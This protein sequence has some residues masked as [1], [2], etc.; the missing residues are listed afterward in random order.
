MTKLIPL[1]LFAAFATTQTYALTG[2]PVMPDYVQFEAPDA[3]NM[4]DYKSGDF[5][6]NLPLG[7]V[8]GPSGDFPLSMSYHAGINP[9]QEATWVGLGW[10]LN[11]GVIHRNVNGIADDIYEGMVLSYD[12]LKADHNGYGISIGGG[13]GPYGLDMN[14]SS[15]EGWG[16][17]ASFGI[18]TEE[19]NVG[20][21]IGS[22][23][24]VGYFV[25]TIGGIG[26]KASVGPSGVGV[27]ITERVSE[28]GNDFALSGSM[29]I[30]TTWEGNISVN[31]GVGLSYES[32]SKY[33]LELAGASMSSQSGQSLSVGGAGFS[34]GSASSGQGQTDYSSEE[35]GGGI[36][37]PLP[38]YFYVSAGYHWYK[39]KW[40]YNIANEE[41]INGYMYQG[42]AAI[43]DLTRNDGASAAAGGQTAH[44]LAKRVGDLIAPGNTLTAGNTIPWKLRKKGKALE[45]ID[46]GDDQPLYP[47][48]DDYEVEAVGLMGSFR[49]IAANRMRLY[50]VLKKTDSRDD[51]P[52]KYNFLLN[53]RDDDPLVQRDDN[54]IAGQ[55]T[56]Y[57]YGF[58]S[59]GFH[60][61]YPAAYDQA[62]LDDNKCTLQHLAA[63]NFLNE[64]NRLVFNKD[65]DLEGLDLPLFPENKPYPRFR[66]EGAA[67]SRMFF[68]FLGEQ[69]GGF[70][71]ENLPSAADLVHRGQFNTPYAKLPDM[72]MRVFGAK[73]IDPILE[74]NS[75][76]G[77][78]KGF[79][80][81]DV[82][83]TVY[84]FTQPVHS[85]IMMSYSTNQDKGMPPV[86]I[87][88]KF[89]R[90]G[91][92]DFD[93]R[94]AAEV[95]AGSA[96][97]GVPGAGTA[98]V[99]AMGVSYLNQVLGNF[100]GANG[101]Y[102][103]SYQLS[104][105]PYSTQW[106]LS[107]I[108]GPNFVNFE[109]FNNPQVSQQY[110]NLE[111]N[112]KFNYTEP[113]EIAW[114][115]P[116]V[117]P[118]MGVQDMT[119][120][121][122]EGT[123]P[124]RRGA[125]HAEM[126]VKE[127]V[128]LKS[129]ET[130]T[131]RADFILNDKNTEERPDSRGLQFDWVTRT[132][133]KHGLPIAVPAK[134]RFRVIDDG[135]ASGFPVSLGGTCNA[136]FTSR[137]K[138]NVMIELKE[139]ILD[140]PGFNEQQLSGMLGQQL[141]ITHLGVPPFETPYPQNPW[142]VSPVYNTTVQ[143]T[144]FDKKYMYDP[145]G[146]YQQGTSLGCPANTYVNPVMFGIAN[147]KP[148]LAWNLVVRQTPYY[149]LE[150]GSSKLHVPI[151]DASD[152]SSEGIE[153]GADP[154]GG[155]Y[156]GIVEKGIPTGS[157]DFPS[158]FYEHPYTRASNLIDCD[159]PSG[160]LHE[161]YEDF[162][163]EPALEMIV[164]LSEL[165]KAAT[166]PSKNPERYLK[167]IEIKQK[168]PDGTFAEKTL[169]KFEFNYD[170]SLSPR[171]P[172]S[173]SGSNYPDNT[174]D[175][176]G[177]LTLKTVREVAC[178]LEKPNC[179]DEGAYTNLPPWQFLYQG[180]N[181]N[182]GLLGPGIATKSNGE[183][184]SIF[185]SRVYQAQDRHDIWGMYCPTCDY[186]NRYPE[187]SADQGVA[188]NLETVLSP[189]FAGLNIDYERDSFVRSRLADWRL[190][191]WKTCEEANH[192]TGTYECSYFTSVDYTYAE[193]LDCSKASFDVLRHATFHPSSPSQ[194]NWVN[195]TFSGDYAT[196]TFR[197]LQDNVG[198]EVLMVKDL[199]G[200]IAF[201]ENGQGQTIP[202]PMTYTFDEATK[203]LNLYDPLISRYIDGDH[204]C[205]E[206]ED[207]HFIVKP[208]D[209]VMLAAGGLPSLTLARYDYLPDHN[210]EGYIQDIQKFVAPNG[211]TQFSFVF[212]PAKGTTFPFSTNPNSETSYLSKISF[213]P[214]SGNQQI[215]G[216][217]LRV[218]SLS[219]GED[220]IGAGVNVA[221]RFHYENG[222]ILTSPGSYPR[223]VGIDL[224]N[225]VWEK[226]WR[227]DEKI[228]HMD[229]SYFRNPLLS[230]T[231]I[232]EHAHA[233]AP[234]PHVLYSKVNVTVDNIPGRTE[235]EFISPTGLMNGLSPIYFE[236]T[237]NHIID[238]T[239]LIG[240][241]KSNTIYGSND[242]SKL[243][244][245]TEFEY[246]FSV[247][248]LDGR[249][250]LSGPAIE[251]LG[252]FV[253][254]WTVTKKKKAADCPGTTCAGYAELQDAEMTY[255]RPKAFLL[256]TLNLNGKTG[257]K[258]ST[259]NAEF[260]PLTGNP[261]TTISYVGPES[262]DPVPASPANVK[263]TSPAYLLSFT[264]P[265]SD[266][267][268]PFRY[269]LRK[270]MLSQVVR[271]DEYV[272][273][274]SS[275]EYATA[276]GSA[277]DFRDPHATKDAWYPEGGPYQVGNANSLLVGSTV[278]RWDDFQFGYSFHFGASESDPMVEGLAHGIYSRGS[279]NLRLDPKAP[280]NQENI[281]DMASLVSLSP[282]TVNWSFG[283]L[284][285][286]WDFR[287]K[288]RATVNSDGVPASMEY[289]GDFIHQ[290]SYFVNAAMTVASGEGGAPVQGPEFA[291][292]T[293]NG[294]PYDPFAFRPFD[295]PWEI[296]GGNP[297]YKGT[298]MVLRAEFE[299]RHQLLLE[300]GKK[301]TIE[302]QVFSS[303]TQP[304]NYNVDFYCP[305]NSGGHGPSCGTTGEGDEVVVSVLPG[306]HSYKVT[307]TAQGNYAGNSVYRRY[308]RV[309]LFQTS[310][311]E[312]EKISVRYFRAYPEKAMANTFVYDG[313]GNMIQFV[314]ENNVSSYFRYN[315]MGRLTAK[316][317]AEGRISS[318]QFRSKPVE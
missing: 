60:E 308:N 54:Y 9:N 311:S 284:I 220:N 198:H 246:G 50:Q 93:Y 290:K 286:A 259:V 20:V 253:E 232:P 155:N 88:P 58:C 96:T 160:G 27:G 300:S 110:R 29:G 201:P 71:S 269:M 247:P 227:T 53:P 197:Q 99:A 128:Y 195:A 69:S 87:E 132:G 17:T 223:D 125:F 142:Q 169:R 21:T 229:T 57:P 113:E 238:Q 306:L 242:E 40:R 170:W 180:G 199:Y 55:A 5:A 239:A 282:Q 157:V 295:E 73:R 136:G 23:G 235:Y 299:L 245:R 167:R 176:Q 120:A 266:A 224:S 281:N 207:R 39:Q 165:F 107:E 122:N 134:G 313:R 276:P 124:K 301:Y 205:P 240:L 166:S 92:G 312:S 146:T 296:L 123:I 194:T 192:E 288:P 131:H 274:G 303:A 189:T 251:Q 211:E 178:D 217:G 127:L 94:Q 226:S 95:M 48:V 63:G 32:K 243:I 12:Y 105:T 249:V 188:W 305:G 119:N 302:F 161:C 31:G 213:F 47:A 257:A 168:S 42:G 91:I 130:A 200:I 74:D 62:L 315:D 117:P 261:M 34:Y 61:T 187:Y 22:N 218:K 177:K 43:P 175:L 80:I 309:R 186:T 109:F 52:G 215:P 221:T 133:P 228:P 65:F 4:V 83:G 162:D 208:G 304:K 196:A 114:R 292:F 163:T 214:N 75:P 2:G 279:I 44:A 193:Y 111:Y 49:P 233:Y 89:H 210:Y 76:T 206:T 98:V 51:Y 182:P 273:R 81:T 14:Y 318:T 36:T 307:L 59:D 100:T 90:P 293:A 202:H 37:I 297:V 314:D 181:K 7:N 317:D 86:L 28:E 204:Y 85:L 72:N 112:V 103:Y 230:H 289:T 41:K 25:S 159:S 271:E 106:L 116:Y 263:R 38:N 258:T 108:R 46:Q 67:N 135:I 184:T 102:Q 6:Y 294:L 68:S 1:C 285:T 158:N 64:G 174:T 183:Y 275:E 104:L 137:L 26:M 248:S 121:P 260:D 3:P 185:L 143:L 262:W 101:S 190:P 97:A 241:T 118:G 250:P 45:S 35:G 82:D 280:A 149:V 153:L 191:K 18:H 164:Q 79:K 84:L 255:E 291:T 234:S 203:T 11:P 145:T 172:N 13:W 129:I 140:L 171:T 156:L 231:P 144:T 115:S 272:W 212:L 150:N 268:S 70:E 10:S 148:R 173:Y 147:I 225:A 33:S 316:I 78:L 264:D 252:K 154:V 151:R 265:E 298:D 56:Q 179:T 270:N 15:D 152:P 19:A 283:S 256:R 237:T 66:S 310:L 8:P 16:F 222:Q 278:N 138:T 209:F 141:T 287:G 30:H 216:D 24:E 219:T 139:L 77:A 126:G 254:R 267:L 244:R 277:P 236:T